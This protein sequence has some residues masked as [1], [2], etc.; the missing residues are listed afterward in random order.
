MLTSQRANKGAEG[1]GRF[2]SVLVMAAWL[3]IVWSQPAFPDEERHLKLAPI[4][5]SSNVGGNLYYTYLDNTYGKNRIASQLLGVRVLGDFHARSFFWQ[6]WFAQISGGVLFDA[7]ADSTSYG[8][9]PSTSNSGNVRLTGEAALDLLKYSRFPFRAHAYKSED[10]TSGTTSGINGDYI[11]KGYDLTQEYRSLSRNIDSIVQYGHNNGG[12]ASVGTEEVTNTLGLNLTY[13][14]HNLSNQSFHLTGTFNDNSHPLIGDHLLTDLL[15]LNHLYFPQSAFSI[16]TM[17]NQAKSDYTLQP[18]SNPQIHSVYN[19]GQLTSFASWRPLRRGLTM[20]SSVRLLRSDY[21][22]LATSTRNDYSNFNLGANYAWSTLLRAYGSVN[23]Y[24]DNFGIQTVSTIAA[25]D[26]SKGFGEDQAINLGGFHYSRYASANISNATVTT[27]SNLTNPS[28]GATQTRTTSA[29][30]L[31]LNL[32]HALDKRTSLDGGFM[33][34]NLNQ[35][36]TEVLSSRYTPHTHL[37]SSASTSWNRSEGRANTIFTLRAT[38]SRD[39]TGFEYFSQMINLQASR[40]INL[41][42]NQAMDGN[43]TVQTTRGGSRYG[44]SEFRTSPSANLHYGNQRLFSVRN[45]TFDSNLQITAA[46][47][48]SAQNSNPLMLSTTSTARTS[49][50]NR[51]E[52]TIGRLRIKLYSHIAVVNND[53]ESTLYFNVNRQF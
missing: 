46:D 36:L 49:W 34:T 50:D 22:N 42:H 32:G 38:D 17:V 47:I 43:L 5:F 13:Q 31:G 39:L 6:P 4:R 25:L 33:T 35:R 45:M 7:T 51:L 53:I 40:H 16:A 1:A 28:G 41:L 44:S 52:Y 23:V 3:I 18:G 29:Q 10:H 8:P 27:N 9:P 48:V 37:S 26:A 30:S 2:S 21:N 14:P 24:D 19:S 12:R 20:T 11:N 15:T